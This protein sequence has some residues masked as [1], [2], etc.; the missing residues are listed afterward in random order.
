MSLVNAFG[1]TGEPA[2]SRTR[3]RCFNDYYPIKHEPEVI[4]GAARSADEACP[5]V[6]DRKV[7]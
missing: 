5:T 7:E 4:L 2:E 3:C 6:A 1:R